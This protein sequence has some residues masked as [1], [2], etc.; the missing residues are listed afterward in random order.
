MQIN[1]NKE[2]SDNQDFPQVLSVIVSAGSN[3]LLKHADRS[4]AY[5][6]L[7]CVQWAGYQ[8]HLA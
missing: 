4:D 7:K 5:T 8:R 2:V 6:R 1:S 3:A